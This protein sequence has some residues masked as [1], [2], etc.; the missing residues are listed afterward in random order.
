[1]VN[2]PAGTGTISAWILAS[3]AA[4]A[5][6]GMNKTKNSEQIPLITGLF[7]NRQSDADEIIGILRKRHISRKRNSIGVHTGS[8]QKTIVGSRKL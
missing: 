8:C 5:A 1:M 6:G 4:I 7:K 2:G 3:E